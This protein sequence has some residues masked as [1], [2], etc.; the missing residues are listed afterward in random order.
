MDLNIIQERLK[1]INEK[2]G[3][4]FILQVNYDWADGFQN[5]INYCGYNIQLILQTTINGVKY[6]TNSKIFPEMDTNYE[7]TPQDISMVIFSESIS[8][9]DEREQEKL[10]KL[11]MLIDGFI[12]KL[13][14]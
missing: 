3:E 13:E 11:D 9:N 2:Y 6:K 12:K 10:K 14:K 5:K 4:S 1:V 7:C 8:K